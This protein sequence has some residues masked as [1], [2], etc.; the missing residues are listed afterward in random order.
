MC[1]LGVW[2]GDTQCKPLCLWSPRSYQL[3]CSPTAC[4]VFVSAKTSHQI[5]SAIRVC[6]C[7]CERVCALCVSRCAIVKIIQPSWEASQDLHECFWFSAPCVCLI[8]YAVFVFHGGGCRS[9]SLTL[10]LPLFSLCYLCFFMLLSVFVC[11]LDL[12]FYLG[13]VW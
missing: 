7:A 1:V 3:L 11:A 2:V 12:P 4:C 10:F 9:S 6:G 8:T 5:T 13:C